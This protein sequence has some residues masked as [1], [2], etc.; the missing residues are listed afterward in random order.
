VSDYINIKG[1]EIVDDKI[2]IKRE[3]CGYEYYSRSYYNN[4]I[5]PINNKIPL[6]DDFM[7]LIG[8]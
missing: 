4:Q 1:V 7:R 3:S 2:L 5:L 6:S 8:Y